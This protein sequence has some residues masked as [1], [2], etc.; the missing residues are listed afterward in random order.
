MRSFA[1]Y[2]F[3]GEMYRC[4]RAVYRG[5]YQEVR[6]LHVSTALDGAGPEVRKITE[7][8]NREGFMVDPP[9]YRSRI[10]QR[11]WMR[12]DMLLLGCYSGEADRA[13][14]ILHEMERGLH[15]VLQTWDALWYFADG[16]V[17]WKAL[18]RMDGICSNDEF[19]A[20]GIGMVHAHLR[21][22]YD[23][24]SRRGLFVTLERLVGD[25]IDRLVVADPDYDT[26][27][28]KRKRLKDKIEENWNVA[29]DRD[30]NLF[31]A[32]TDFLLKARNYSA[33]PYESSS[34]G[35]RMDSWKEFK[36]VA[37]RYGLDIPYRMHDGPVEADA[38]NRQ[39]FMKTLTIIARMAK[40]WLDECDKGVCA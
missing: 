38:Q 20:D 2:G 10:F 1:R 17:Y 39:G 24:T 32:V 26:L 19:S 3:D 14:D 22:R 28:C 33:H 23:V 21:R 8:M 9:R 5:Q 6:I 30:W 13:Y 34:F 18:E 11:D 35:R 37:S 12:A 27:G 4:R 15:G 36:R 16:R 29:G 7:Y 40:A 31:L 25:S